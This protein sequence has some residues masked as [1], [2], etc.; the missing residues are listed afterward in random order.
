MAGNLQ[1]RRVGRRF[2]QRWVDRRIPRADTQ[3]FRQRNIFIVP[4]G[5][6][7]VFGGLLLIMLLTGINYQNSLIYLLTFVLG[8]IFVAAMHQTHRNLLGFE[9]TVV[10]A[11]DAF[12]GQSC[13]FVFKA[14]SDSGEAVAIKLETATGAHTEVTVQAGEVAEVSLLRT[15]SQRGPVPLGRFRIESRFPFGL[16][17][18]WSWMRPVTCG[19]GYPTLVKPPQESS[20][21]LEGEHGRARHRTDETIHAEIRPWRE[22]D[23]S[24][25]VLW[26]RYARSGEMVIVDWEGEASDPVWLDYE[27]WP[28]VDRETRLSYLAYSVVERSRRSE[29]YGLRLPGETIDPA[30]G[31][32]HQRR[33]LH[34]LGRYGLAS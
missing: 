11:S 22:G 4:T 10:A 26:K 1:D 31:S 25:R 19:V 20:G 8:A 3:A 24:Q 2:W 16:L 5:A 13:I 33:C 6:G 12:Q 32:T 15:A 23:L 21:A 28:G 14:R 29:S 34:A 30:S 7:L 18:A 9:L 27:A 17:R